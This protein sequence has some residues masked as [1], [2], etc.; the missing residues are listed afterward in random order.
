MDRRLVKDLQP[1]EFLGAAFCATAAGS[2]ELGFA[3]APHFVL[4]DVARRRELRK[5]IPSSGN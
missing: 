1:R 2:G 3:Q 5:A 4:R